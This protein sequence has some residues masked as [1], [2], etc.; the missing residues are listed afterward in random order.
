MPVASRSFAWLPALL[1]FVAGGSVQAAAPKAPQEGLQYQRVTFIASLGRNSFD[2]RM[3]SD[4]TPT[5]QGT[6]LSAEDDLGL[7]RGKL[8]GTAELTI[9]V[10]NRH[11][12]RIATDYLAMERQGT[13]SLARDITYG[14]SLFRSGEQVESFLDLRR[15]SAMYLYSPVRNDGLELSVGLGAA[16]IDFSSAVTLPARGLEER[17]DGTA[18]APSVAIEGLWHVSGKWYLE[19]R[20]SHLRGVVNEATGRL[21][22]F[23]A[24]AVW[25]W[26]PGMAFSLGYEG[27]HVAA[28]SR[29][30][31]APG[32]FK[33]KVDGPRLAVRVGF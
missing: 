23:S 2:T 14:G 22:S 30:A 24:N 17:D 5:L 21:T 4:T 25:E 8:A 26:R 7:D 9:R 13:A 6:L 12:F 19:G 18:P 27:Y 10:R 29:Y 16:L 31:S 20:A 32:A 28:E 1:L 3:R 15:Y 11:R 33:L